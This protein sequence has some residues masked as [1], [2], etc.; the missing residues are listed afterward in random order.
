MLASGNFAHA[1]RSVARGLRFRFAARARVRLRAARDWFAREAPAGG[2]GV[3]Q[4]RG[5]ARAIVG[6]W[7]GARATRAGRPFQITNRTAAPRARVCHGDSGRLLVGGPHLGRVQ[8]LT[9][10][11]AWLERHTESP[12]AARRLK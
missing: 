9:P 8:R 4:S 3:L 5:R 11:R 10:E 7:R 12:S 2:A 6:D 1:A